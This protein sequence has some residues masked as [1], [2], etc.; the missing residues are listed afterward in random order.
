MSNNSSLPVW[1]TSY[2]V[3]YGEANRR[4]NLKLRALADYFQEA[5]AHH[6]ANLGVGIHD[7]TP[8]NII[9][10]LSR[11]GVEIYRLPQVNDTVTLKTWPRASDQQLFA[12]REFQILS[13]SGEILI[14]GTSAWLLLDYVK[15]RPRRITIL[16]KTWPDNSEYGYLYQHLDEL[17]R[18]ECPVWFNEQ[19]RTSKI[20]VNQHLNNAEYFSWLEDCLDQAGSSPEDLKYI[21]INFLSE[22]KCGDNVEIGF[23][24]DN[25][26]LAV[27]GTHAETG[28]LIFNSLIE[29]STEIADVNA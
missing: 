2:K 22:A 17:P 4:G 19:I 26:Q 14:R 12:M 5:A 27:T 8:L 24:A 7:L 18:R 29:Y 10:V 25:D 21:F 3:R 11:M 13:E 23:Q 9:W 1:E 15:M 20:D 16:E 28:K 6:A